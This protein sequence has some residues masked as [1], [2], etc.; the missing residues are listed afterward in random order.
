LDNRWK[1]SKR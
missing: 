1:L